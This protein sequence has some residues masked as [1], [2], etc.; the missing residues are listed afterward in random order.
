MELAKSVKSH[1]YRSRVRW[2]PDSSANVT[3]AMCRA[4]IGCENKAAAFVTDLF[5]DLTRLNGGLSCLDLD[6]SV[7]L[8]IR[9]GA[10]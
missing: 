2:A 6:Q 7:G 4:L 9:H 8:A 1:R 3:P 10:Y 5:A